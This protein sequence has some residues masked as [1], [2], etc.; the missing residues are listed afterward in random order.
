MCGIAG[1]VD[2]SNKDTFDNKLS[3]LKKIVNHQNNRGPDSN[4]VWHSEDEKFF[5]GFNWLA[6]QDLKKQADQ[7]FFSKDKSQALIFNGEIFNFKELKNKYLSEENFLTNSDTEVLFKLLIKFDENIVNELEGF[8]S[9]AYFDFNKNYFFLARD[10]YGIK[11]LYYLIKNEILYFASTFKII[12]NICNSNELDL[13]STVSFFLLGSIIGTNTTNRKIKQLEPGGI[14]NNKN[15]KFNFYNFY[16][17]YQALSKSFYNNISLEDIYSYLDFVVKKYCLSEAD[18]S[19]M[20][21]SGIDSN[22]L[23]ELMDDNIKT[24]TLSFKNENIFPEDKFIQ[25][26]KNNIRIKYDYQ[27]DKDQVFNQYIQSMEQPS[28]DGLNI[29]II[30]KL[31]KQYNFKNK[32]CITGLGLDELLNGYSNSNK[33]LISNIIFFITKYIGK[34]FFNK[35]LKNMNPKFYSSFFKKNQN[36][37]H[38]ILF[39]LITPFEYLKSSYNFKELKDSFEIL[40]ENF[41]NKLN[42]INQVSSDDELIFDLLN[43]EFYLKN[44]LLKDGDNMSM[45]N[46]IELRFPY[47]E[48]NFVEKIYNFRR[49]NILN[50]KIFAKKFPIGKEILRK[51][52]TGFSVP[53]DVSNNDVLPKYFNYQ[54]KIFNKFL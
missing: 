30:T 50:K 47:L 10:R 37:K 21:S 29:F 18:L 51:K 4:S 3:S 48:H 53:I 41:N 9:F 54:N 52:K 24:Y 2:I 49:T 7:P 38:F 43:F 34:N 14:L 19:L 27:S 44:Q 39:R 28:I 46:S 35:F 23:Y 16:S 45:S 20:L 1:I 32:V 17:F 15:N 22:I 25:L 31:I 13:T 12:N 33:I 6:I 36:F 5:I 40:Y 11:P 42:L 8:F 26:K